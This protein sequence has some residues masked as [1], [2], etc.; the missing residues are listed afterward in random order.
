MQI[1]NETFKRLGFTCMIVRIKLGIHMHVC[2]CV[3]IYGKFQTTN[4]DR[5]GILICGY[6]CVYA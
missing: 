3:C 4:I 2:V 6:V 5:E 1:P